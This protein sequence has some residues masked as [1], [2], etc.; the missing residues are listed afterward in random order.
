MRLGIFPIVPVYWRDGSMIRRDNVFT[1]TIEPHWK[2][3]DGIGAKL[4]FQHHALSLKWPFLF[5]LQLHIAKYD[6]GDLL[7]EHTDTVGLGRMWRVQFVL[8][9]A[10]RGG[11]LLCERFVVNRPRFKIFEPGKYKHEVTE[12]RDG[13][14]LVLNFGIWIARRPDWRR[15]LQK[16]ESE[17]EALDED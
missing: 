16:K 9:N 10:K 6:V 11:D 1:I 2:R 7:A 12:V 5:T 8:R 3:V 17:T 4:S 15:D 13:Q 14:R